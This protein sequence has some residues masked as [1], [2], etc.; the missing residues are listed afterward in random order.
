LTPTVVVNM[1][2]YCAPAMRLVLVTY[3]GRGQ[4]V[5]TSI[6]AAL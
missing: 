1:L 6:C 5:L 3:L 2:P 4:R